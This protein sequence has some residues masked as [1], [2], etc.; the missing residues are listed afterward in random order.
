M[1]VKMVGRG[2]IDLNIEHA[3]GEM[4]DIWTR[5]VFSDKRCKA[6]IFFWLIK[7][8]LSVISESNNAEWIST[9]AAYKL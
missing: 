5:Q 1:K 2:A 4:E 9:F 8:L 6:N 3:A 7:I